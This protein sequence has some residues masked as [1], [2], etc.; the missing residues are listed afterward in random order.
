MTAEQIQVA[1]VS[2]VWL[3]HLLLKA[4]Y[5]SFPYHHAGFV[6]CTWRPVRAEQLHA[7]LFLAY[8]LRFAVWAVDAATR[9]GSRDGGLTCWCGPPVLSGRFPLGSFRRQATGTLPW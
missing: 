1:V 5:P 2:V 8:A 7:S 4:R 9:V 3:L 6:S